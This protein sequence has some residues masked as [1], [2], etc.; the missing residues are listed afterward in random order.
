M[1]DSERRL[2]ANPSDGDRPGRILWTLA[3]VAGAIG[4]V[5]IAAQT[6]AL[7]Q[8]DDWTVVSRHVEQRA[9]PPTGKPRMPQSGPHGATMVCGELA[10]P[11]GEPYKSIV[12]QIDQLWGVR[13]PVYRSVK[14]YPP[15]ATEA[16]CIFYNAKFMDVFLR[17]EANRNGQPDKIPMIYAIMAHEVGHIVHRDF[18][19]GRSKVPSVT[20]ELQADRFSGYTLS[21]LGI[22]R[23]NITPYYSLGGDEFSG[24][25]DHGFSNQRIAAFNEGWKLAEWNEPENG[26][27]SIKGASSGFDSTPPP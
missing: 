8:N 20:K 25:H 15:H 27:T 19:A 2:S 14:P 3:V 4:C 9:S 11:A 26:T 18:S 6:P 5:T 24:V 13:T 16:G 17:G 22:P 21:R 10:R 23:D 7:A 12:A 1:A